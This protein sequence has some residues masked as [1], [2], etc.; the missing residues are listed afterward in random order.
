M[1]GV[2]PV[3]GL[4]DCV[5]AVRGRVGWAHRVLMPTDGDAALLSGALADLWFVHLVGVGG[6]VTRFTVEVTSYNTANTCN[7]W[8]GWLP[9]HEVW[10]TQQPD[11]GR[12]CTW[13]EWEPGPVLLRHQHGPARSIRDVGRVWSVTT[14]LVTAAVDHGA[15]VFTPGNVERIVEQHR[16]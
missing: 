13:S 12:G 2:G 16:R 4:A 5:A 9:E 7:G 15:A 14:A 3:A 10:V 8:N 11:N 6:A 1:A